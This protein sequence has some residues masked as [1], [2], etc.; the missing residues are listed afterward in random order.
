MK[1]SEGGRGIHALGKFAN[2]SFHRRVPKTIEAEEIH[3]FRGL[4][5]GPFLEGYT[6]GGD[7][8]TRAIVA[9]TA[10]HENLLPRSAA[11]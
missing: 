1:R 10:M 8:H 5:R 11:E 7:E 9:E 6:I 3:F 2:E 4:F